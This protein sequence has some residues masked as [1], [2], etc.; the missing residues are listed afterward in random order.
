MTK[1]LLIKKLLNTKIP[2]Y[3]ENEK[4]NRD[5]LLRY[6]WEVTP[7]NLYR[8]C[9]C[10]TFDFLKNDTFSLTKPTEFNDP[11]DSLLYINRE[12]IIEYLN[13]ELDKFSTFQS[14]QEKIDEKQTHY[15]K[16]DELIDLSLKS[17]KQSSLIACL[18]ETF[19]SI[20]MWSHYANNHKGFV[21]SYNFKEGTN[22]QKTRTTE[23]AD[24]MLLPVSYSNNRFDATEYVKFHY[25]D[26]FMK[27]FRDNTTNEPFF[28]KLFY[29]KYL[30]FKSKDWSYEREWRIIKL[31][32]SDCSDNKPDRD[33]IHNI[34][35]KE[36]ILGAQIEKENKL[37]LIDIAKERDIKISEMKLEPFMNEYKLSKV[38]IEI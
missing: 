38:N 35:P 23:F 13:E 27:C 31:T 32:N 19:E 4:T 16:L 17:L 25:K 21:L 34:R 2:E 11:Y 28:D 5:D 22:I 24:N 10:K 3:C 6:S 15:K 33:V 12:H 18:S 8:Y 1:E 7:E 36:I 20:L 37:K 9:N 26:N 30:L 14:E 29:Y